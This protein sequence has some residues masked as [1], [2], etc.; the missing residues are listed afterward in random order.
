[1][2][3]NPHHARDVESESS[4]ETFA[5]ASVDLWERQTEMLAANGC[6]AAIV[7][8]FKRMFPEAAGDDDA[9]NVIEATTNARLI[10][11]SAIALLKRHAHAARTEAA[12]EQ[13]N[14]LAAALA[15]LV[16][17]MPHKQT[18]AEAA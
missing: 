10:V 3:A 15:E 16:P 17:P 9:Q 8:R 1:M 18:N 5:N 12:R 13:H 6:G 2:S 14:K 4:T 11:A 7:A